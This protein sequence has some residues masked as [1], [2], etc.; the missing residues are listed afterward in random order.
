M[1][2]SA[3]TSVP[4]PSLLLLLGIGLLAFYFSSRLNSLEATPA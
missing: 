1:I 2:G 4:E 3:I